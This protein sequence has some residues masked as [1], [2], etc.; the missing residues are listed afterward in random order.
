M[1]NTDYRVMDTEQNQQI[2]RGIFRSLLESYG[3]Y[4]SYEPLEFFLHH[5][6]FFAS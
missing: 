5:L 4:E 1:D 2:P 6:L 3:R